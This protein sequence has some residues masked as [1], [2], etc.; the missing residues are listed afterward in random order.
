VKSVRARGG[1]LSC[2]TPQ[3][4][5]KTRPT[6]RFSRG[7]IFQ[8]LLSENGADLVYGQPAITIY[9]FCG[10]A[11]I[12]TLT[13]HNNQVSI[14][15]AYPTCSDIFKSSN[16]S[17]EAKTCRS[18]SLFTETWEK[19]SSSFGYKL[20]SKFGLLKMWLQVGKAVPRNV[21]PSHSSAPT[22]GKVGF[23]SSEGN[24]FS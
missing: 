7:G 21:G 16:Q 11:C 17:A 23:G 1:E 9:N 4:D 3:G 8:F 5:V 18:V 19:K 24:K 13:S 20:C 10:Q 2:H 14:T 12:R 22:A 6:G 15:T